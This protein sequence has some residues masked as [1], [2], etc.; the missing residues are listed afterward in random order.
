[1]NKSKAKTQSTD[2]NIVTRLFLKALTKVLDI[3]FSQTG[4]SLSR[5]TRLLYD[6]NAVTHDLL[7]TLLEKMGFNP[8]DA[9]ESFRNYMIYNHFGCKSDI[10]GSRIEH[11]ILYDQDGNQIQ[12]DI[13]N[14][15]DNG[16]TF[17]Q[18]M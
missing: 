6:Q 10:P 16:K 2:P 7:C 15:K 13:Y 17:L 1:M 5:F 4:D 8:M 11:G 14:A 18:C 9:C 12:N 3:Y